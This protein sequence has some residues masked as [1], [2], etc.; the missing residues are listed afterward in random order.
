M[1]LK[2]LLKL[3][4]L[5]LIPKVIAECDSLQEL[6]KP[7]CKSEILIITTLDEDKVSNDGNAGLQSVVETIKRF[8]IPAMQLEIPSNGVETSLIES[9][10]WQD[11]QAKHPRFNVVVF[12]NGR[13]SYSSTGD[14]WKSAIRGDQWDL[15]YEY[16]RD[17]GVSLVFLNEYPSNHTGTELVGGENQNVG[18][19]KLKQQVTPAEDILEEDAIREA[20]VDTDG[21]W[22]F[23][24]VVKDYGNGVKASPLLYFEP[25]QPD[26]PE[27]TLAAVTCEKSENGGP[28][29]VYAGFFMGFG[30]WSNLSNALNVVWLSW[31]TGK[32]FHLLSGNQMTSAEAIAMSASDKTTKL[33]VLLITLTTLIT[34]FVTLF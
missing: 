25:A 7:K 13:V 19:Y 17:G 9:Y 24:A 32:D 23:P 3:A 28:A 14:I 1:Q 10:L 15:F 16:S 30:K 18:R 31:A 22:H 6:D 4:C 33:E 12:P 29:A 8:Q 11:K 34:V 20:N 27:R 21:V 2:S 26:Y 5:A